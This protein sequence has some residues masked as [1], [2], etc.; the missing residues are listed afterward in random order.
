MQ[1]NNVTWLVSSLVDKV[2]AG[3][4]LAIA[5]FFF[6]AGGEPWH[7]ITAVISLSLGVS[8]LMLPKLGGLDASPSSP[9]SP[10]ALPTTHWRLRRSDTNW[11]L[12]H[13][14]QAVR[15]YT[16]GRDAEF[17]HPFVDSQQECRCGG[18]LR[19]IPFNPKE[20]INEQDIE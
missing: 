11:R 1:G 2:L 14:G 4:C 13:N 5:G 12:F 17:S 19:Q 7:Y 6:G 15:C 16:C 18:P 8:I 9:W 20:V 3:S 10:E